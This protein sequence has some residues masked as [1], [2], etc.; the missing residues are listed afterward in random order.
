MLFQ[1]RRSQAWWDTPTY[2]PST[3]W[4][5]AAG[6]AGVQDH[7]WL[8]SKFEIS[9]GYKRLRLRSKSKNQM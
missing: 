8:H 1:H 2:N 3:A 7:L 5:V 6:E 9:L 4:E